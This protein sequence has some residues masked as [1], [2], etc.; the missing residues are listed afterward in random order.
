MFWKT[1]VVS[2]LEKGFDIG[3][4]CCLI[5]SYF[6]TYSI[7]KNKIHVSGGKN[8]RPDL[9]YLF[10]NQCGEDLRVQQQVVGYPEE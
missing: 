10:R 9:V 8:W 1:R 5:H 3:N 7:Y 4:T 6:Q 2:S